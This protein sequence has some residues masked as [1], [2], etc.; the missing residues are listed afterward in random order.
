MPD[1]QMSLVRTGW[2]GSAAEADLPF[3]ESLSLSNVNDDPKF[4]VVSLGLD[5]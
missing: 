2:G 1:E 4:R 3:R 5:G